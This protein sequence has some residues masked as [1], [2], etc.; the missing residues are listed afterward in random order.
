MYLLYTNKDKGH[1][2]SFR[3]EKKK[4]RL[5]GEIDLGGGSEAERR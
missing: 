3:K 1:K 5:K 4:K 2:L